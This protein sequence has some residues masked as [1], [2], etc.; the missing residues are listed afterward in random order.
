[1]S[2]AE[3]DPRHRFS[4]PTKFMSYL[5]AGLPI[6]TLGHPECG[7]V[8]LAQTFQVGECVASADLENLKQRVLAAL[9]L[10][11]PWQ[12]FGAEILRCA[13]TECDA[14]RSREKLYDGLRLCAKKTRAAFL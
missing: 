10:E 7:V 1:M 12:Q 4:L 9:A 8:K 11:N 3:D 13:R 6:F 5:A 14:V 2:L